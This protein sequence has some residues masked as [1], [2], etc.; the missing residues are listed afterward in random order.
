MSDAYVQKF[1]KNISSK[2]AA[3][4]K[5]V[6]LILYAIV[7][8]GMISM[9]WCFSNDPLPL[10][11]IIVFGCM[12]NLCIGILFWLFPSL[13]IKWK[14]RQ[15]KTW[16]GILTVLNLF[17]IR[18]IAWPVFT[19]SLFFVIAG[20]W[21]R[22]IDS[23][24]ITDVYKETQSSAL[25]GDKIA[26]FNMGTFYSYGEE[27]ASKNY[28]E[29]I[30]WYKLSADQEF[31]RAQ[32][33]LGVAYIEGQG[34]PKDYKEAIRW[35]SLAAD[36]GEGRAQAAL[37]YQYYYGYGVEKNLIEAFK[38][39]ALAFDKGEEAASKPLKKLRKILSPQE[40]ALANESIEIWRK[41]HAE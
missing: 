2:I 35:F 36:Q 18:F 5:F 14:K 6:H 3:Y 27:G 17:L 10:F 38:W 1:M 21:L 32:I 33:N 4:T 12:I 31:A 39:Y 29:A 19:L 11:G 7:W 25:Q 23:N 24:S 40:L 20:F 34:V 26:Q 30:K 28:K 16:S 22:G 37:G 13:I 15:G 41:D 9:C 8:L